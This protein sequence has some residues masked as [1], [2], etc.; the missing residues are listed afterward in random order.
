[1]HI[2]LGEALTLFLGNMPTFITVVLAWMHSNSRI[3]DMNS[4]IADLKS[5]LLRENQTTRDILR[6]EFRRVEDVTDARLRH[7][8]ERD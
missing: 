3:S 7:L 5:E 4:R 1:M 2:N 8:E 6:A